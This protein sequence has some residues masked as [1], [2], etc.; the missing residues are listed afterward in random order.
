MAALRNR[1]YFANYTCYRPSFF[2]HPF[3]SRVR[4]AMYIIFVLR[5]QQLLQVQGCRHL[6]QNWR[7][8]TKHLFARR[9]TSVG[10]IKWWVISYWSRWEG[11]STW[12]PML[13]KIRFY[14]KI[15]LIY[16]LFRKQGNNWQKSRFEPKLDLQKWLS[17]P[18]LSNFRPFLTTLGLK[19]TLF[20][21][22]CW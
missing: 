18:F 21:T 3:F 7:F 8:E 20:Y 4:D 1:P 13:I 9:Y 11:G 19:L 16:T 10:A 22:N 12:F 5:S 17:E 6:G 2:P 14:L 15:L